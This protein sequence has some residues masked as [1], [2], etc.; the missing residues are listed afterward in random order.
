MDARAALGQ[1]TANGRVLV[2]R[3]EEFELGIGELQVHDLGPVSFRGAPGRHLQDITIE[4][5]GG[6]HVRHGDANVRDS[7]L[8]GGNLT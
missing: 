4:A 3:L 7:R 1:E 5:K 2:D 8:H 6:I